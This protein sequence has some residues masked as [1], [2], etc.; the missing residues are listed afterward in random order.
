[1]GWTCGT[2]AVR[3]IST[4]GTSA[5]ARCVTPGCLNTPP[6]RR[7]G[8]VCDWTVDTAYLC[9]PE[10]AVRSCSG[11]VWTASWSSGRRIVFFS[12][13]ID[14]VMNAKIGKGAYTFD[15]VSTFKLGCLVAKPSQF[16]DVWFVLCIHHS[17]DVKIEKPYRRRSQADAMWCGVESYCGLPGS[18]STLWADVATMCRCV[19]KRFAHCRW[20]VVSKAYFYITFTTIISAGDAVWRRRET[21]L[22]PS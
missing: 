10:T 11:C 12:L 14:T 7:S 18:S 19:K 4:R 6:G 13:Y 16:T 17:I 22:G 21:D 2:G 15:F 20:I 9:W 5:A 8:V 1:M 3:D